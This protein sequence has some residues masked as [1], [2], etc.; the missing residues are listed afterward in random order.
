[1]QK[2]TWRD[3]ENGMMKGCYGAVY[4]CHLHF[5]A[6]PSAFCLLV[7]SKRWHDTNPKPHGYLSVD[8]RCH[9]EG[10]RPRLAGMQLEATNQVCETLVDDCSVILSY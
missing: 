6:D 10:I 3:P 9:G 5:Y 1:M 4:L 8:T 2:L 7:E